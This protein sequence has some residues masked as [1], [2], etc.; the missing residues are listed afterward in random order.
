MRLSMRFGL[1]CVLLGIA[2]GA[3]SGCKEPEPIA[4]TFRTEP[5]PQE[6]P[7]TATFPEPAE[8]SFDHHDPRNV[9]ITA[10]LNCAAKASSPSVAAQRTGQV[11]FRVV[12]KF[13]RDEGGGEIMANCNC[14]RVL[15]FTLERPLDSGTAVTLTVDELKMASAIAP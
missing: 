7:A 9:L 12:Q 2:V 14:S 13:P 10:P 1:G 4:F 5:C 11:E 15:R 3:L 8:F 6:D